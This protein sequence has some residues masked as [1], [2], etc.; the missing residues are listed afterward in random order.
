MPADDTSLIEI[1]EKSFAQN[2]NKTAFICMGAALSFKEVDEH[3][4]QVA[5][6]LQ[7]LGLVKGDKVAVMMPNILQL[8][9]F[10]S[11]VTPGKFPTF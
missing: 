6:Y 9:V 7:S 2:G 11:T 8:P 5:V 4:K 3:S 1:F 10:L